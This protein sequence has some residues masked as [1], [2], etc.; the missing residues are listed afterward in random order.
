MHITKNIA[1]F[2]LDVSNKID[3]IYNKDLKVFLATIFN[4]GEYETMIRV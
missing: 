2:P 3:V 1:Y 4:N